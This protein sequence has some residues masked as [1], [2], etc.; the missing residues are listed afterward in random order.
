MNEWLEKRVIYYTR[1]THRIK[2]DDNDLVAIVKAWI[3]RTP[4]LIRG[5]KLS[6]GSFIYISWGSFL[7]HKVPH[8]KGFMK[9]EKWKKEETKFKVR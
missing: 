2:K 8:Y 4:K 9:N 6:W 5:Y 3:E 1:E 7:T